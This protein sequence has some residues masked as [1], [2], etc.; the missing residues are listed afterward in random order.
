[1]FTF[2]INGVDY[3]D[4]LEY[5]SLNISES[6]HLN[7][8]QMTCALEISS[9]P[10]HRPYPKAGQA[11]V[12]T[13]N[14][15]REFAGRISQISHKRSGVSSLQFRLDC[16]DFTHDFDAVLLQP[17]TFPE[18]KAGQTVRDILG[19]VQRDFE[20]VNVDDGP[21]Y[22]EVEV[23]L[24]RPSG[25]IQGIAQGTGR[26]FYIDYS[27]GAHYVAIARREDA[28]VETID[29]DIE[30]D[31][32]QDLEYIEDWSQV[33]NRLYITDAKLRAGPEVI[34]TVPGEPLTFFPLHFEPWGPEFTTVTV[35]GVNQN[36]LLEPTHADGWQGQGPSGTAYLCIENRGVRFPD[37]HPIQSGS[38]VKVTYS[39]VQTEPIVVQD[40][41]S[42]R[43]MKAL[44]NTAIAS[45]EGIHEMKLSLPD[46]RLPDREALIRYARSILS[47]YTEVER[48][49]NFRSTVQGWRAGQSFG[50]VS[51]ER[52]IAELDL[53]VRSV[54]KSIWLPYPDDQYAFPTLQYQVEASSSPYHT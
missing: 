11:L 16:V 47:R 27:K 12:F 14:G 9:L 50:V 18:Q 32:Y 21:P 1:M 6:L 29:L 37:N 34:T 43:R 19:V 31:T 15:V 20:A 49:L 39:I 7:G 5:K 26:Q 44:E 41:E 53:Y 17:T 28:V 13:H 46:L 33:K 35:N 3:L 25:I 8:S 38:T 54:Q 4:L 42:I 2:E 23:D 40:E 52:S 48:I 22:A 51:A 30:T 36:I 10:G 24:D 45:S